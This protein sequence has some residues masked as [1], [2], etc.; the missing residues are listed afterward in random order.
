MEVPITKETRHL[1]FRLEVI[2][3]PNGRQAVA[4]MHPADQEAVIY[5]LDDETRERLKAKLN[6]GVVIASADQLPKADA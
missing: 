3:L 1:V 2:D 4:A 6:G 5:E